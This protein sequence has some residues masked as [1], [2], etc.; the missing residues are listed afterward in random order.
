MELKAAFS[1][2]PE[3]CSYAFTGVMNYFGIYL[4]ISLPD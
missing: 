2:E 4:L 1:M 3:V